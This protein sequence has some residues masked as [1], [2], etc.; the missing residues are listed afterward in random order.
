MSNHHNQLATMSSEATTSTDPNLFGQ[1]QAELQ[2]T[3]SFDI[4]ADGKPRIN[5]IR[6]TQLTMQ[7][8]TSDEHQMFGAEGILIPSRLAEGIDLSNFSRSLNG[9]NDDDFLFNSL[10]SL[11]S[12]DWY[13]LVPFYFYFLITMSL[14]ENSRTANQPEFMEH[15]GFT[16]DY[17]QSDYQSFFNT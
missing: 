8:Q 2:D 10:A 1:P 17:V 3:T 6:T 14:P 9:V 4:G 11:D 5:P 7:T 13:D 15:L 16:G 12:V